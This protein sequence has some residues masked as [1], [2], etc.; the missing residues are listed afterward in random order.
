[1]PGRRWRRRQGSDV[2]VQYVWLAI[3]VRP[4]N[5]MLTTLSSPS[6]SEQSDRQPESDL[7]CWRPRQPSSGR[8]IVISSC[9]VVVSRPSDLDV[10]L[11]RRPRPV[12]RP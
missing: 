6:L 9:F 7:V 8:L 1:M 2:A 10:L 11:V 5:L 12:G 4:Q 3:T